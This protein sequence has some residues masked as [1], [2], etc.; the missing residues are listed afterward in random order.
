[1]EVSGVERI[2][3]FIKDGKQVLLVSDIH[4]DFRDKTKRNPL[5]LPEF[6][7]K[8][9]SSDPKTTWD[10][11]LE[12]R[13]ST[14]AG[15]PDLH[16]LELLDTYFMDDGFTVPEKQELHYYK[17]FLKSGSTLL[18]LTKAYFG[19]K[20]CFLARGRGH[21]PNGRFHF[22]DIRQK[23]IG[24]CY[25]ASA[26]PFI[27]FY[28]E[29]FIYLYDIKDDWNESSI[30]KKITEFKDDI[31]GAI[32]DLLDCK[33]EPKI[34]KQAAKSIYK[35]ELVV[36]FKEYY[37]KSLDI[38]N[39]V[40]N[41]WVKYEDKIVELMVSDISKIRKLNFEKIKIPKTIVFLSK[42]YKK[43]GTFQKIDK[44][45]N[46]YPDNINP[47]RTKVPIVEDAFVIY[48]SMLMNMYALGRITKP[49][50]KNVVVIAGINHI[51][52]INDFLKKVGWEKD[53]ESKKVAPKRVLIPNILRSGSDADT[54]S[55]SEMVLKK[56][57]LTKTRVRESI[58]ERKGIE[59]LRKTKRRKRQTKREYTTHF[60][61][62]I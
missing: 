26:M 62:L 37:T 7:D 44:I 20:G 35:K 51:N 58:S 29:L 17:K 40:Y 50:N 49:Y 13:V 42:E 10:V 8:L 6:I 9:I 18:A 48:T 59:I 2:H 22:I 1:M 55:W 27:K 15:K 32:E 52:Y 21:I 12:Q 34:L 5:Y 38:L 4:T 43:R 36:F 57:K 53:I 25:F 60:S 56:R 11:Y 30:Y 45:A 19:S 14:T 23:N 16:F 28:K 47:E 24:D 3:R 39:D 33:K 54:E 61:S 31:L 46:Y 41:V